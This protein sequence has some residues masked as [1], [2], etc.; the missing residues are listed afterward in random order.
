MVRERRSEGGASLVE[1]I[2]FLVPHDLVG[3]A[4]GR[5]GSNVNEARRIQGIISIE[6]NDDD[7]MFEIKG[8]VGIHYDTC[9]CSMIPHRPRKLSARLEVNSSIPRTPCSSLGGWQV[10]VCIV[11]VYSGGWLAGGRVCVVCV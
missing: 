3:L 8:E 4:I 7:S 11:C 2:R 9:G 10:G 5:E 1:V 6:Y